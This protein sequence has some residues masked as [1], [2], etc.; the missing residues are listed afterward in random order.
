M[1]AVSLDLIHRDG[2]DDRSRR[3]DRRI[4]GTLIFAGAIAALLMAKPQPIELAVAPSAVDFGKLQVGKSARQTVSFTNPSKQIFV[5]SGVTLG[6]TS[7][8]FAVASQC[9]RLAG[10]ESCNAE[11]T[12]TPRAEGPQST[13]ISLAGT[14]SSVVVTGFGVPS[15]RVVPPAI[16]HRLVPSVKSL[17]FVNVDGNFQGEQ[18]VTFTNE[19]TDDVIVRPNITGENFKLTV[20]D[21]SKKGM[22]PPHDHC[23]ATI[24]SEATAAARNG[25]LDIIGANGRVEASVTLTGAAGI[26]LPPPPPPAPSPRLRTDRTVVELRPSIVVTHVSPYRAQSIFHIHNDGPGALNILNVKV[27]QNPDSFDV[28]QQCAGSALAEGAECVVTVT[29]KLQTPGGAGRVR[30]DSNS[31]TNP[32]FVNIVTRFN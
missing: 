7:A 16:V 31:A 24:T 21:C 10:G 20:E 17:D 9:G 26:S 19:G 12:F 30:I 28:A 6:T 13:T 11:V 22:L 3:G 4:A 2:D 5:A 15:G 27:D 1:A 23:F 18:T 8:D 32:D 25:R 14:S 29:W